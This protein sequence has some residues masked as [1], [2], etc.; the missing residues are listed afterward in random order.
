MLFK[1]ETVERGSS[2]GQCLSSNNGERTSTNARSLKSATRAASQTTLG[3][4]P[5]P[6]AEIDPSIFYSTSH[7]RQP[8]VSRS[9]W[10]LGVGFQLLKLGFADP[11]S[12]DACA[13]SLYNCGCCLSPPPSP[14]F[15]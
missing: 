1:K 9:K 5:S 13:M 12:L 15:P 4:S 11:P 8:A 2:P 7:M 14:P 10:E 3:P 6:T